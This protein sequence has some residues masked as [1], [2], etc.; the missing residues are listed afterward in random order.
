[1]SVGAGAPGAVVWW[2]IGNLRGVVRVRKVVMGGR[3]GLGGRV[4]GV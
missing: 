4:R 1:M 3:E 2:V